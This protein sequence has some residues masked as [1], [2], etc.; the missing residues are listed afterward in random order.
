VTIYTHGDGSAAHERVFLRAAQRTSLRHTAADIPQGGGGSCNGGGEVA[1][2]WIDA[3]DGTS[4]NV[5]A[6]ATQSTPQ[7]L[8]GLFSELFGTAMIGP[9]LLDQKLR[10]LSRNQSSLSNIV[11]RLEEGF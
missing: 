6:N 5:G 7:Q 3:R 9:Q 4:V 11:A 1:G 2:W 10:C 8:N